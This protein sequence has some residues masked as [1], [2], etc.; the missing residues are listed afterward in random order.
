MRRLALATAIVVLLAT[1]FFVRGSGVSALNARPWPLEARVAK[2]AW[3]Y[4]IPSN[5]RDA[6]NP[7][8]P[9]QDVLKQARAHWADHCAVCHDNNGSGQTTIGTRI[10]PRI[11]DLRSTATQRLTDGE[12]MY[13]IEEGI[14]WTA[15]P[16]WATR[17][18]NGKKESWG[19]VRFIR[20]LP[21]IT[22]SELEEMEALNPKPP[23][24]R[25][26]EQEIDDFLKGSDTPSR[27]EAPR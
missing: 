12:L 21:S 1:A 20:H 6:P 19:L 8:A 7:V 17:T 2:V 27:S 3:R 11:P 25:A 10:Y 18:E 13:A 22:A 26:R 4:L 24:N 14:P 16:G 5:V 15:M 23:P 9:S